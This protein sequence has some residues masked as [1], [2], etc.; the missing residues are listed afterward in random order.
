M[1]SICR[2]RHHVE[3]GGFGCPPPAAAVGLN[4]HE[5]P[6]VWRCPLRRG[7]DRPPHGQH[8]AARDSDG[9]CRPRASARRDPV[10]RPGRGSALHRSRGARR[11]P[12]G[13]RRSRAGERRRR[14]LRQGPR[15]ADARSR[16]QGAAAAAGPDLVAPD[17]APGG[18]A[19]TD[20]R[21][22][23]RRQR[24]RQNHHHL[25]LLFPVWER[26]HCNRLSGRLSLAG[27]QAACP[28]RIDGSRSASQ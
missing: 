8:D 27:S 16:A 4:E 14:A 22:H 3:P 10:G 5:K 25:G 6:G 2:L 15:P 17:A 24:Q 13:S 20:F 23:R 21:R 12:H 19:R 9:L 1:A 7:I 18:D 11:H 28:G 26:T